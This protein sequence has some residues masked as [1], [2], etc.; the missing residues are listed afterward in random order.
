[1]RQKNGEI[2]LKTITDGDSQVTTTFL[3]VTTTKIHDQCC[4]H[5]R[6]MKQTKGTNRCKHLFPS[7]ILK[8][9]AFSIL[10]VM[11]HVFWTSQ[12]VW[13]KEEEKSVP[14]EWHNLVFE[15]QYTVD[16]FGCLQ[17]SHCLLDYYTLGV[18]VGGCQKPFLRNPPVNEYSPNPQN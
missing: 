17:R 13:K 1:M 14:R 15:L 7:S 16:L 8:R 2:S 9:H 5:S 18:G 12:S 4:H 6:S 10:W 3:I 11:L